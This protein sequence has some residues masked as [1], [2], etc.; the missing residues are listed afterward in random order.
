M[1]GFSLALTTVLGLTAALPA[2]AEPKT[3]CAG[4]EKNLATYKQMYKILFMDRD[5]SRAGEFY[6]PEV[7]SHNDDAGGPGAMVK[8]EQMAKMWEASKKFNPERVL[9]DELII[10]SGDYVV[11]RTTVR[12]H[13]NMGMAGN[14]PTKKAYNITAT[15]I[16]RFENGKVVER[17]GNAD[18]ASAFEQVGLKVVPK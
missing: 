5:G 10:C 2:H 8:P 11:V 3:V 4:Q 14:A 15:D 12:T 16:Y 13:D 17:W 18:L 9:D 7:K 6:A 1:R